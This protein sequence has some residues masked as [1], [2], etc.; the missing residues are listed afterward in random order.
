M[1]RRFRISLGNFGIPCFALLG[2]QFVLSLVLERARFFLL[3]RTFLVA[4]RNPPVQRSA[5]YSGIGY[6][7][8][9]F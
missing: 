8:V 6:G 1:K 7:H 5:S 9:V 3:C 2:K 4:P